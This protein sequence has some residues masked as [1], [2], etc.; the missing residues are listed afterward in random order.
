MSVRKRLTTRKNQ[1]Q[2]EPEFERL[3]AKKPKLSFMDEGDKK[4]MSDK[5][6]CAILK[7]LA[8]KFELSKKERFE[9]LFSFVRCKNTVK[10]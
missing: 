5:T 2:S 3:K 9:N 6:V 8:D 7:V 10:I 1:K 4:T